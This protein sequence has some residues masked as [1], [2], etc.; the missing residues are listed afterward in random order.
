LIVSYSDAE[1]SSPGFTVTHIIFI[2][3]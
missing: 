1:A 3:R 2:A